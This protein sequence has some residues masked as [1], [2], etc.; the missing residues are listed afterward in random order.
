MNACTEIPVAALVTG[1]LRHFTCI[2]G[3]TVGNWM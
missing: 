2:D 3:L 1:N